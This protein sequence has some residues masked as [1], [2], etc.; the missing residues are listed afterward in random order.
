MDSQKLQPIEGLKP[1]LENGSNSGLLLILLI[2][3]VTTVLGIGFTGPEILNPAVFVENSQFVSGYEL[4]SYVNYD[5][6]RFPQSVIAETAP[7]SPIFAYGYS[8]L[9]NGLNI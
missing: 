7:R 1:N 8:E 3:L 6:L 9:F 5:E 2:I 4:A